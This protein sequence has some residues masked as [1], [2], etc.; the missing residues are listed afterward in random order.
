MSIFVKSYSHREINFSHENT[1]GKFT[2]ITDNDYIQ[3]SEGNEGVIALPKVDPLW[4]NKYEGLELYPEQN[5]SGCLKLGSGYWFY[6]NNQ[7]QTSVEPTFVSIEQLR[8]GINFWN[9]E[10][11]LLVR[12]DNEEAWFKE[13]KIAYSVNGSIIDYISEYALIDFFETDITIQEMVVPN[14]TVIAIA[15]GFNYAK[16]NNAFLKPIKQEKIPI[17]VTEG[18]FNMPS[19][20]NTPSQL[21]FDYQPLVEYS[22]EIYQIYELPCILIRRE[23]LTEGEA[24]QRYP[25]L[26]VLH[27]ELD[28]ENN[29]ITTSVDE[30]PI[31][32]TDLS[33]SVTVMS[34]E[35]KV[36]NQILLKLYEKMECFN[37]LHL[38]PFDLYGTFSYQK[39]IDISDP[40]EVQGGETVKASTFT[41]TY[42]NLSL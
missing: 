12:L 35:Y 5:L 19:G 20:I 33:W 26:A 3:L 2:Y 37:Y 40:Q 24:K 1:L 15:N 17:T 41:I 8:L 27:S 23:P 36:T 18:V 6:E 10:V 34:L 32:T 9:N 28:E 29:I 13:Y 4:L 16:I 7:W 31:F 25:S 11:E 42:K 22:D 21:L 39:A 14:S 30:T 38:Q